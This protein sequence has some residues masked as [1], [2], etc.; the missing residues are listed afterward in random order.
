MIYN[1]R[2]AEKHQRPE[3][4]PESLSGANATWEGGISAQK[5]AS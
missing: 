4:I 1:T 2:R 5:N 3:S